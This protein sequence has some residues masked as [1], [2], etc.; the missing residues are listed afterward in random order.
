MQL[1][2]KVHIVSDR[3]DPPKK[4]HPSQ[5]LRMQLVMKA[6]NA[7]IEHIGKVFTKEIQRDKGQW[8]PELAPLSRDERKLVWRYLGEH[9]ERSNTDV[10]RNGSSR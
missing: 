9:F 2:P 6:F 1:Q 10:K 8:W 4:M 7:G 5:K 3:P